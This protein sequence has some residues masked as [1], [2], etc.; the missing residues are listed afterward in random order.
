[1][2]IGYFLSGKLI[3]HNSQR[4]SKP[5][6]SISVLSVALGVVILILAFAITTGFQNEI[7]EKMV[8][9]GSHIEISHFDNNQSYEHTPID[10]NLDVYR[11]IACLDH[12]TG[13]YPFAMKAGI[14]RGEEDI[15]GVVFKGIEKNYPTSFFE[16]HLRKGHFLSLNDSAV[17]D[18]IFVSEILSDKLFLDTGQRLLTYFVQNPVRQRMFSVAGI[19][20]TGLGKY[21]KNII[22]CDI[23]HVQKL[24]DWKPNQVGG[25]EVLIDDFE[26]LELVNQQINDMLPAD[27]LASTVEERSRDIFGWIEMFNQNVY[28]LIVLIIVVTSVSLISTQLTIS[29]EHIPTIGI[30]KTLGCTN[31]VI[32]NI[33]LYISAKILTAGLVFGNVIAL[34]LC[35]LQ[36]KYHII[37]LNPD[38]YYVSFVP[39][40]VNVWHVL[41]INAGVIL[42]SI[43][44]LV[45]PSFFVAKKTKAID[46]L[47]MD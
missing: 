38:N 16:K 18:E 5:I 30:L 43:G 39:V 13:V 37:G 33:F 36:D 2:N 41:F 31:V 24:N 22:L 46:A 23:G 1:L 42:I 20:N 47:Q 25:I 6:V 3:P 11:Q 45:I 32:R 15:E 7:K 29:L 19:Y 14:V 4:I 27:L 26:K 21:D 40:E 8:G 17:S 10:K 44:I 28:I 9:F 12:V 35:F 34:I